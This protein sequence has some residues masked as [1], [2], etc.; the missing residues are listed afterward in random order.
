M[1]LY[2]RIRYMFVYKYVDLSNKPSER[3]REP[4]KYLRHRIVDGNH[5]YGT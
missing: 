5:D 1:Y 2:V 4:I 3:K